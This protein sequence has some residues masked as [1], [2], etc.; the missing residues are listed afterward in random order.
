MWLS[1]ALCYSC[2]FFFYYLGGSLVQDQYSSI[3]RIIV[4][5][6]IAIKFGWISMWNCINY[7]FTEN[8]HVKFVWRCMWNCIAIHWE[9]ACEICVKIHVELYSKSVWIY[10]WKSM[11]NAGENVCE[12]VDIL[13]TLFTHVSLC[14]FSHTCEIW[15]WNSCEK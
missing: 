11:W 14:N 6:R 8:L 2:F 12:R 15:V 13:H 1:C 7:L 3:T 4:L 10:M 9:F 5:Q